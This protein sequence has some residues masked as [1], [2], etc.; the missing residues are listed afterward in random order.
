VTSDSR[1]FCE[2]AAG[3]GEGECRGVDARVLDTEE[4]K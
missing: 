4:V 2:F 1:S 3:S